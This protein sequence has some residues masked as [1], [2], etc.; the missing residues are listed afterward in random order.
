MFYFRNF[1]ASQRSAVAHNGLDLSTCISLVN[2]S[3]S[4]WFS[5]P[6]MGYLTTPGILLSGQGP[7]TV[8]A[9]HHVRV[10]CA[11]SFCQLN[12]GVPSFTVARRISIS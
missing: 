3:V 8:P 10:A 9:G 4:L 2:L 12:G 7:L 6:D 1:D 11:T 5:R